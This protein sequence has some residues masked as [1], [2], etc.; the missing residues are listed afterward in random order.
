MVRICGE[1]TAL[2]CFFFWLIHM[3]IATFENHRVYPITEESHLPP[4]NLFNFSQLY[5]LDPT[6][7]S[8]QMQHDGIDLGAIAF[9]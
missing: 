4:G 3:S 1:S 2:P 6:V 7:L 9:G 8:V 5:H